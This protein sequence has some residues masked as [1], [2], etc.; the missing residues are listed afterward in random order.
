MRI[1]HLISSG[2]MYGAENVVAALAR[3][4][5]R[6]GHFAS[7][8][9]FENSHQPNPGVA[10]EFARRGVRVARI[11]CKGRFDWRTIATIRHIIQSSG[12]EVVHT[13]GYKSDIY[14]FLAAKPLHV[15]LVATCHLWTRQTLSLR[16]YEFIDAMILRH[17]QRVVG[18]SEDITET[19]RRTGVQGHKLSTIHNGT[20]FP[21]PGDVAETLKTELGIS[22]RLLIGS[23]GRLETQKGFEYFIRAAKSILSEFPSAL[24]VIVG[25]GSQRAQLSGL[26][27][28]MGLQSHVLLLG[29]RKDMPRIYAALDVF[30]LA[31]VD[32]GM[33]MTLLEALAAHCP[34]VATRVGAVNKLILPDRTGLLVEPRDVAALSCAILR[35]LR[36]PLFAAELAQN[37]EQHIRTSFSSDG[38]ARQYLEVYRQALKDNPENVAASLQEA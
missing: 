13:H 27:D 16:A 38:M 26:I 22:D 15:P 29:Q 24:F 20:D 25:E 8:G 19:V 1:L 32:E 34:V 21:R 37:G 9:V 7:V 3:E 5:E 18:V 17:A 14:G 10:D 35:F 28:E 30:V 6:A 2:G 4:L 36:N 23:V 11:P 33:P 12:F 31:S